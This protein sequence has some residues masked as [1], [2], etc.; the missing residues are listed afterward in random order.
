MDIVVHLQERPDEPVKLH[1]KRRTS[2]AELLEAARAAFKLPK[3][4][5]LWFQDELGIIEDIGDVDMDKE[6]TVV[7]KVRAVSAICPESSSAPRKFT[8]T[9][10]T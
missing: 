2:L 6:L 10:Q 8:F 3:S 9:P 1:K 4:A 7:S 5:K